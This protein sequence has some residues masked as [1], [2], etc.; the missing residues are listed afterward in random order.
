MVP[1]VSAAML[2]NISILIHF[3]VDVNLRGSWI[4]QIPRLKCR[5]SV[6][7]A[8]NRERFQ[9]VAGFVFPICFLL[10]AAAAGWP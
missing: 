8:S 2:Q 10:L 4:A 1:D 6:L 9:L 7:P 5:S 3:H